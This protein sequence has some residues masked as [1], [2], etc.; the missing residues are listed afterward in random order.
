MSLAYTGQ[1]KLE[2]ASSQTLLK[3]HNVSKRYD[4]GTIAVQNVRLTINEGDFLSFVGPS[5]CGKSTLFRLIA[6]LDKPSDGDISIYG[7]NPEQARKNGGVSYVFQDATLMPWCNVLDN[8]TLPLKLSNV[9]KAE[10]YERGIEVL[11]KVGLGDYAKALPR[12]LS[13]GMKMRASIAR[14]L[15]SQPKLLLMDEPFG[16]LDEITRQTLQNELLYIR[17]Q[18]PSMT[19]LFVTHNVFEAVFLSSRVNVMSARPGR[20]TKDIKI[21]VSYPRDE[22]FR[23]TKEFSEF[24]RLVS[25]DL[26]AS[27]I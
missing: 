9:S 5:G 27:S 20:I 22:S 2:A 26:A 18:D 24:V 17:E 8:V 25:Q 1:T 15:I 13:G 12:Q 4:E 10:Q 7:Q 16:A 6:G 19:I 23:T 11:K 14:A 3:L 21:P